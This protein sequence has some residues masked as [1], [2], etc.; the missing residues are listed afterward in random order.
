M[1][2]FAS[3]VDAEEGY[4]IVA[5]FKSISYVYDKDLQ[6][7]VITL[8]LRKVAVN[9]APASASFSLLGLTVKID[10]LDC[11]VG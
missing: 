4:E 6:E 9:L 2:L 3:A 11:T 8:K 7:V 5:E 1:L 10:S